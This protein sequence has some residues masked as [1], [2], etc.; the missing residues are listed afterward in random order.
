MPVTRSTWPKY[1]QH[2]MQQDVMGNIKQRLNVQDI[3]N[4]RQSS[5]CWRDIVDQVTDVVYLPKSC[6]HTCQYH[7]KQARA[8][9]TYLMKCNVSRLSKLVLSCN[10]ETLS[11]QQQRQQLRTGKTRRWITVYGHLMCL[12]RFR[13]EFEKAR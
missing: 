3:Q 4:L 6:T 1:V 12:K 7:V 11:Y 5:R 2:V 9:K 13:E 8:F 10:K